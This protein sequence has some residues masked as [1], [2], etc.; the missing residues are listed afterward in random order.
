MQTCAD[1]V[2]CCSH[3]LLN[4]ADL[5]AAIFSSQSYDVVVTLVKSRWCQHLG[6]VKKSLELPDVQPAQ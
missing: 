3:Q 6:Q 4:A 2:H 1:G 5:N